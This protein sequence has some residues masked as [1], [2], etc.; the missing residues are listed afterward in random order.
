MNE[1]LGN[2]SI[3]LLGSSLVEPVDGGVLIVRV[4]CAGITL[5]DVLCNDSS[6]DSLEDSFVT[7]HSYNNTCC[8]YMLSV[9]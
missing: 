8:C 7:V 5:T 6:V 3:L 1:P 9:I 4:V 2:W